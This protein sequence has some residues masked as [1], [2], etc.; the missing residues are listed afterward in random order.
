MCDFAKHEY[1]FRGWI[2]EVK[3]CYRA[4]FA[5]VFKVQGGMIKKLSDDLGLLTGVRTFVYF[6][7][8]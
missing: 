6:G 2:A 4:S 7:N 1:S 3:H 8:R 5:A